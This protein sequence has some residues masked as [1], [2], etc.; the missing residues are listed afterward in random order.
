MNAKRRAAAAIRLGGTERGD[1]RAL[2]VVKPARREPRG[3][4][5]DGAAPMS[6]TAQVLVTI[7]QMA[8]DP[9]VNVEK[10]QAL[11]AMHRE[12]LID[13]RRIEFFSELAALADKLPAIKKD[14]R[15]AIEKNGKVIQ[16]TPFATWENIHRHITPVLVRSGFALVHQTEAAPDGQL[17]RVRSTLARNGHSETTFYDL[18]I[19]A[20]GSKNN[21]QGRGSSTSYGKRYNTINLL[22]IRT[23]GEDKDGA[24]D[25]EAVALLS[26]EQVTSLMAVIVDVVGDDVERRKERAAALAKS[27]GVDNLRQVAVSDYGE[28][29]TRVKVW[30]AKQK[31]GK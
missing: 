9:A 5:G 22:N 16:N 19:D 17:L 23:E 13:Q 14:G 31:A 8:R 18:P 3:P 30:A 4:A 11:L 12:L 20:S 2:A 21:V 28:A 10:M 25:A 29:M 6:E 24:F 1:G 26:D 7:N 27:F 15:L